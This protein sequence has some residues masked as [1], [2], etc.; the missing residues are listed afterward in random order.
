ML[1][2]RGVL[3]A[4]QATGWL[5]E[6]QAEHAAEWS[7]RQPAE[8]LA[9]RLTGSQRQLAEWLAMQPARRSNR[10]FLWQGLPNVA[11]VKYANSQNEVRISAWK[12][13]VPFVLAEKCRKR[14]REFFSQRTLGF[15]DT[16]TATMD[17]DPYEHY[18]I[19]RRPDGRVKQVY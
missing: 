13:P 10:W 3:G 7:F 4:G 12:R 1:E 5:A 8:Q 15:R 2:F 17:Y 19:P 18:D 16:E 11:C 14:G 9:E 6:Q